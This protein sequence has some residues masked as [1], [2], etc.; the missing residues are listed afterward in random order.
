[1]GPDAI[2]GVVFGLSGMLVAWLTWIRYRRQDVS[3]EAGADASVRLDIEYIKRG[4]D[5]IQI[6]QRAM[7]DD[8]GRMA[9]RLARVEESAK[10]AHKRI[11]DHVINMHPPDR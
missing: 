5:N 4:V 1:M 9:D 2:V 6:D 8:M 3:Q 7:R 11:D 10:S